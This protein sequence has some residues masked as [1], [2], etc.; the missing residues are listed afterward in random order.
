[1]FVKCRV[2]LSASFYGLFHKTQISDKC[3]EGWLTWDNSCYK[4]ETNTALVGIN[5]DDGMRHCRNAYNGF[6]TVPNSVDEAE[7]LGSYLYGV[8]QSLTSPFTDL[9]GYM[10]AENGVYTRYV[11]YQDGSLM[12]D[13]TFSDKDS[14][15]FTSRYGAGNP[16]TCFQLNPDKNVGNCNSNAAVFCEITLFKDS[17]IC[18]NKDFMSSVTLNDTTELSIPSD[19]ISSSMCIEYCRGSAAQH[20]FAIIDAD[21]CSCATGVTFDTEVDPINSAESPKWLTNKCTWSSS[22]TMIGNANNNV[23]ALYNIQYDRPYKTTKLASS[24]CR[25]FEHEL[26]YTSYGIERFSLQSAI[27]KPILRVKCNYKNSNLCIQPLMHSMDTSAVEL[28]PHNNI[29]GRR[30][31]I[32]SKM[33]LNQDNYIAYFTA[34]N[35]NTNGYCAIKMPDTV[36]EDG[37]EIEVDQN[38][39]QSG[40]YTTENDFKLEISFPSPTLILGIWWSTARGVDTAN[41][42][43]KRFGKMEYS[44]PAS[45][46]GSSYSSTA[47]KDIEKEASSEQNPTTFSWFPQ[48]ILTDKLILSKIDYRVSTYRWRG[49]NTHYVRFSMELYGC[50]DYQADI[51]N[52]LNI[53]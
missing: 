42:I 34:C 22:K 19:V 46:G 44:F 48:P 31:R 28:K 37:E 53:F 30:E 8:T 52:F 9:S 38:W 33:N 3:P 15:L 49:I 29:L 41:G 16:K 47:I 1:M 7:F 6:L 36:D 10:G 13:G 25:S 12:I 4:L 24:T 35:A 17:H 43:I 50:Q 11:E 27:G 2:S 18:L 5:Q 26:F 40:H 39:W 14:T 20:K 21:K 23:A 51:S 45:L 32:A